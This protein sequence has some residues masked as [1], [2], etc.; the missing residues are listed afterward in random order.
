MG[1]KDMMKNNSNNL[2]K[3]MRLHNIIFHLFRVQESTEFK[4]TGNN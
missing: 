1:S 3:H 4:G 2:I